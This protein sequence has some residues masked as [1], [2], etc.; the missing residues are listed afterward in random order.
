[1]LSGCSIIC[2]CKIMRGDAT[3]AVFSGCFFSRHE[4]VQF[5]HW[6][7]HMIDSIGHFFT[8]ASTFWWVRFNG[9]ILSS[10]HRD[11]KTQ[12]WVNGIHELISIHG[13]KHCNW[14]YLNFWEIVFTLSDL[15]TRLQHNALKSVRTASWRKKNYNEATN[16]QQMQNGKWFMH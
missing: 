8:D 14:I 2:S 5:P 1:M 13:I 3:T 10:P 15:K 4:L 7:S 9:V 6:A 12:P 11:N 16:N